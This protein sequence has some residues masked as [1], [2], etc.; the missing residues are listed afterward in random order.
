MM[1]SSHLEVWMNFRCRKE[2]ALHKNFLAT[3]FCITYLGK[4]N[5]PAC[6]IN[7]LNSLTKKI[8]PNICRIK[9]YPP[10][11]NEKQGKTINWKKNFFRK[12]KKKE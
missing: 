7:G 11:C 9:S 8:R 1:V 3:N 5:L 2:V 6:L 12:L 4:I 10:K